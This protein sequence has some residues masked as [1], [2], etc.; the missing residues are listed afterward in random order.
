MILE[1]FYGDD[2]VRPVLPAFHHL[3][4]SAPS[5]ELEHLV[6]GRRRG[7]HF[8]LHQLVVALTEQYALFQN[9]YRT[10]WEYF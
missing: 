3:A 5:Q 10:A 2:F 9:K 6:S 1:D 7:E 8:M 4:E